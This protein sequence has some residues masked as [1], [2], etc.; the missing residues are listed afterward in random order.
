MKTDPTA[1]PY[2]ERKARPI[3]ETALADTASFSYQARV[4]RGRR[5]SHVNLP[6]AIGLT[7]RWTTPV[8]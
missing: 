1:K 4:K 8:R 3:V 7:S 2:I 5:R 6:M